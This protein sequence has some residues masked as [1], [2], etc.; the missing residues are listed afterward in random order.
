[1]AP[2]LTLVADGGQR[3]EPRAPKRAPAEAGFDSRAA[4]FLMTTLAY[5][6]AGRG[7]GVETVRAVNEAGL[8]GIVPDL[9][10][11]LRIDAER[12]LLLIKGA[13]PGAPGSWLSITP[14]VKRKAP[15]ARR[16]WV[17][18]VDTEG[19]KTAIKKGP[20]KK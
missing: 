3:V 20:A 6:G 12:G 8:R 15:S 9:I 14:T 17:Q 10:V 18:V 11:L 13:V 7:L 16:L 19:A 4:A 2:H 5:Q 1:M